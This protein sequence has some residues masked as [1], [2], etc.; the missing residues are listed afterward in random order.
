M[1]PSSLHSVAIGHDGVTGVRWWR[2]VLW[3]PSKPTELIRFTAYLEEAHYAW[4]ASKQR[5]SADTLAA[6]LR[7][8]LDEAMAADARR[9]ARK[10]SQPG[11]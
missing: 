2:C 9:K 10:S 8:T 4:L 3:M 7:R 1:V 6:V 5:N 11:G